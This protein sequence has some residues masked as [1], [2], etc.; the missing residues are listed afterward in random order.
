[1]IQMQPSRL[2]H[3][4]LTA[5]NRRMSW[6]NSRSFP[7]RPRRR[8]DFHRQNILNPARCQPMTV[9]GRKIINGV[10]H[11]GQVHFNITQKHRSQRLWLSHLPFEDDDLVPQRQ[12]FQ[13]EF[14]PRSEQRPRVDQRH[15][16]KFKH[17]TK[18]CPQSPSNQSFQVSTKF[19]PPTG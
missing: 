9:S 8:R 2:P 4:G 16:E 19:L 3:V 6:I 1:M 10:F 11:L 13:R 7:G 15:S 18:V 14:V 17:T 5:H 12:N